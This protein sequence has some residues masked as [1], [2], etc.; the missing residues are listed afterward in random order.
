M[1]S[2]SS[3]QQVHLIG[4]DPPTSE[5]II[6]TARRWAC[7]VFRKTILDPMGLEM[8]QTSMSCHPISEHD[9]SSFPPLSSISAFDAQDPPFTEKSIYLQN[10]DHPHSAIILSGVK[11]S[12]G[13]ISYWIRAPLLEKHIETVY[14]TLRQKYPGLFRKCQ[15]DS[16]GEIV[17]CEQ[18]DPLYMFFIYNYLKFKKYKI[19]PNPSSLITG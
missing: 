11:N 17:L 15:V 8:N 9:P 12:D 6:Q 16:Q 10:P 5:E 1:T 13:T 18:V 14:P 3:L 7:V 4:N 2:S 19:Q